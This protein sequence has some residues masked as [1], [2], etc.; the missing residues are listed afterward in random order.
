MDDY[1]CKPVAQDTLC[2]ILERWMSLAKTAAQRRLTELPPIGDDS[3]PTTMLQNLR[4]IVGDDPVL[5]S[6]IISL[7]LKGTPLRLTAI[8]EAIAQ[9][10]APAL[11]MAAHR[12]KS[13]SGQMGAWS[14]VPLCNE[15]EALGESGTTIGASKLYKELSST[16]QQIK[17]V[18]EAEASSA[19]FQGH[20]IT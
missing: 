5:Q 14:M 9:D 16:Y 12:L 1:I 20:R 8:E 13:S 7:F 18:L 15:L 17:V 3:V 11:V 4:A 2:E 19:W 10:D 6:E